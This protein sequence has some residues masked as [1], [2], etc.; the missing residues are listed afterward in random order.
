MFYASSRCSSPCKQA[1]TNNSS[2]S[3]RVSEVMSRVPNWQ[4]VE[5]L[6]TNGLPSNTPEGMHSSSAAAARPAIDD[7]RSAGGS[8]SVRCLDLSGKQLG[9]AGSALLGWCMAA[10]GAARAVGVC[11]S[12]E[13]V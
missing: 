9:A 3:G 5:L 12:G 1:A 10:A 11:L 7:E 2:R 8:R 4:Y 6:H 13:L